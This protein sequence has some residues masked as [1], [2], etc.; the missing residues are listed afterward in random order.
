M[1]TRFAAARRS[2]YPQLAGA[3]VSVTTHALLLTAALG[4]G[5][6]SAGAAPA[7]A[8][9]VAAPRAPVGERIRW[10]GLRPT[11]GTGC[12]AGPA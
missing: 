2:P 11:G 3:L 6:P 5:R 1:F 9:P 8:A 4:G 10:V 7:E 12:G